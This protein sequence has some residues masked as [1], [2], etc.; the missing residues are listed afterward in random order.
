MKKKLKTMLVLVLCTLMIGMSFTQMR[1]E[2]ATQSKYGKT[3]EGFVERLYKNILGRDPDPH[4][5]AD[6]CERLKSGRET[7]AQVAYGFIFS[8][9]F[10]DKNF[11]DSQFLWRL[12][13]TYFD[14]DPDAAVPGRRTF[15]L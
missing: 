3:V 13:R 1:A 11:N 9:E 15:P 14:R 6:W 5:F 7:A 12:Y 2:A 10:T 4:G 8:K